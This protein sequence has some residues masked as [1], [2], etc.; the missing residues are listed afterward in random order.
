M[1]Y[2]AIPFVGEAYTARSKSLDSQTCINFYLESGRTD[3]KSPAALYGT[4]GTTIFADAGLAEGR[5]IW[6]TSIGRLFV[7]VGNELAEVFSNGSV[8]VKATLNTSVGFCEM[9]D[10]GFQLIIVDGLNGYILSLSTYLSDYPVANTPYIDGDFTVITNGPF[11]I[12]PLTQNEFPNGTKSVSYVDGYFLVLQD[13]QQG[14]FA[15]SKLRDGLIWQPL[16]SGSAEGSPD[17][18]IRGMASNRRYWTFGSKSVEVFW[19]S[20]GDATFT[21]PFDRI[22]GSFADIGCLSPTSVATLRDLIFWLGASRDGSAAIWMGE[23]YTPKKVS[24]P[25]IELGLDN[26]TDAVGWAYEKEGHAFYV[27]SSKINNKTWCF[28]ITTNSWHQRSYR[29]PFTAKNKNH[30]IIA[31]AYAF[32]LNLVLSNMNGKIFELSNDVYT[33]DGATIVR[34]R[35]CQHMSKNGDRVVYSSLWVD[36]EVGVGLGFGPTEESAANPQL[37]MDYSDDGGYSFGNEL[38]R[39]IGKV[40]HRQE[41]I[42]FHRLGMSRDRVFRI[43]TSAPVKIVVLGAAALLGAED[44]DG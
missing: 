22:E 7:V 39:D 27:V 24:N 5:A 20:G 42:Q 15:I 35:A 37:M 33:D 32:N 9:S 40:G 21:F 23:G 38:W 18:L 44:E 25:A 2:S 29:D 17:K 36:M 31:H 34:E 30:H 14:L 6:S 11:V 1:G 16:D 8:V 43:K 3:S 19:N 41:R 13:L 12:P 4:P 10:N 26:W 28:D